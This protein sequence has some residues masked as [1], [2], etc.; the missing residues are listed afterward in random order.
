MRCR[1]DGGRPDVD[2]DGSPIWPFLVGLI[3]ALAVILL[4]TAGCRPRR[5]AALPRGRLWPILEVSLLQ[6]GVVST[7]GRPLG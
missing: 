3:L 6:L 7:T 1:E 4:G 5:P 2:F